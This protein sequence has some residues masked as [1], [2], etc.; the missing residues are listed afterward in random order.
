MKIHQQLP[1]LLVVAALAASSCSSVQPHVR[2]AKRLPGFSTEAH[3]GG[4]GLMPENTIPAMLDAIDRGV[5]TLEMDLGVTRD[6]QVIVTH[7]PYVNLQFVTPPAG[8]EITAEE[9]KKLYWYSM[10]YAVV[11]Q[12]ETGLKPH[13]QFPRQRKVETHIP[14][15][16]DLITAAEGHAAIKGRKMF[17]DMEIK[18]QAGGDNVKHPEIPDFCEHVIAILKAKKVLNRTIIQSFD[19]RAL[20][21]IHEKY[22]K[23]ML[24][25]LLDRKKAPKVTE[26]LERLG[27]MPVFYSPDHNAVTADLVAACHAKGV[28]VLPWTPN[29]KEDVERLKALGADGIISDYPDLLAP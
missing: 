8:A 5:T 26:N 28:R 16:S 21:Y 6:K 14:L 2:L 24:S 1:K 23:V 22:P 7:D 9:G 10:D 18:T 4:R 3:R 20:Q 13:P 19:V 15:L 17:Y 12:Y 29:T 25:Y 27:F 11:K